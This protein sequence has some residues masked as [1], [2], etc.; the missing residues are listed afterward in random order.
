MLAHGERQRHLAL[1]IPGDGIPSVIENQQNPQQ[2]AIDSR[3]EAL[4]N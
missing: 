1:P 4:Y 3:F 2:I